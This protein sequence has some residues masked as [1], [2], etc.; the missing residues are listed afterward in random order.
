M[1]TNPNIIISSKIAVVSTANKNG[2]VPFCEKLAKLGYNI[3]STSGTL[4][5]LESAGISCRSLS[6][7]INFPEILDGRVKTLHPFIHG[8]LLADRCNPQHMTDLRE[9]GANPIDLLVVNLYPFQEK[10]KELGSGGLTPGSSL[11]RE[12]IEFIDIG[13]PA[14]LRSSAKNFHSVIPLIDPADYYLVEEYL[15]DLTKVPQ[16][17]RRRL[18]AK[19]FATIASYDLAIA[20]FLSSS[21]EEELPNSLAELGCFSSYNGFIGK[22]D[23][24]LRYGENPQQKAA[25]Y[26]H[27]GSDDLPWQKVSGKD[28]SYNNL[29]DL[30]AALQLMRG[31][32]TSYTEHPA[33]AILK[34]TNP[35]GV[36]IAS[37]GV[38]AFRGA[39]AGDPRSHFGGIVITNKE[40]DL[41]LATAINESF[42]E[43]VVAPS[44]DSEA[45]KVLKTKQA[46]RLITYDASYV[47]LNEFRTV[48]GGFLNQQPDKTLI[49]ADGWQI[50]AG[51]VSE[52]QRADL[53]FAWNISRFVKSNAIVLVKDLQL[54]GVGA[55]QMSRIDST[56]VAIS[57]AQGFNHNLDGAVA[58]SDAFFPFPDSVEKLAAVGIKAII[59]PNGSKKDGEVV[60]CAEQSGIGLVFIPTRHFKH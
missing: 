13:G 55:G 40:V 38:L 18:A 6:K 42:Y 25:F 57:K 47:A 4:A 5:T 39:Q 26:K 15:A 52:V 27:L 3:L 32:D 2:V 46:I 8:G 16:S 7:Y 34:H 35:C 22:M 51:S 59:A 31:L 29:L 1:N 56:E 14:M 53:L 28:L 41:E 54:I 17:I 9:N 60:S 21:E 44:Y 24:P 10:L 23:F 50:V 48:E 36:A 12:M 43:L 49:V 11:E 45:L 58:A 20:K 33:V 30:D 19:V 37:S